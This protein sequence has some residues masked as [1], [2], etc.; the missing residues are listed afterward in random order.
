MNI[1]DFD[2]LLDADLEPYWILLGLNFVNPPELFFFGRDAYYS[3]M[4]S[5]TVSFI[6]FAQLDCCWY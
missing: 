3:N 4:Q 2:L 6:C 1:K 5:F